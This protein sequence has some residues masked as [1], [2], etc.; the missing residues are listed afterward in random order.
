MKRSEKIITAILTMVFG[1]LLIA[2]QDRFIGILMTI[3]GVC[4][5]TL[6]L[7]DIFQR[8][9]P[10]AVIKIVSGI[11]VIICGWVLVEAVLYVIAALLLIAC[12]LLL[13]DKIRKRVT[14]ETTWQTALTYALPAVGILIGCLLLFH[15]AFAIKLIFIISGS[16]TVIEGGLLLVET[17]Y[18][19]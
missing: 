8:C 3:G 1:V 2:L 19:E 9:I 12:I 15:Q 13:Y 10:P 4:L 16:L 7:V 17:F 5:L 14:C 6:G 11:L 18:D